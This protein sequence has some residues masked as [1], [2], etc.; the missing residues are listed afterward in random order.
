MNLNPE[1]C[2]ARSGSGTDRGEAGHL[3]DDPL[4]RGGCAPDE[5]VIVRYAQCCT[6]MEVIGDV[7]FADP[8]THLEPAQ[9]IEIRL[10]AACPT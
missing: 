1:P 6:R 4:P 10:T 5:A 8:A 2:A 3:G 9:I 7:T